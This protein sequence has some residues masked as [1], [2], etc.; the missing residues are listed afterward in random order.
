[1]QQKIFP[2]GS[3]EGGFSSN[4]NIP[5]PAPKYRQ[6]TYREYRERVSE[7]VKDGF[8]LGDLTWAHWD[9]YCKGSGMYDLDNGDIFDADS[10]L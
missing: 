2:D 10:I 8:H 5:Y 6:E 9:I 7:L 1:M 4:K 3:I